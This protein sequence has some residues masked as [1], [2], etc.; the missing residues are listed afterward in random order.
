MN[1]QTWK[2][3]LQ[4]TCNTTN[5]EGTI[6]HKK[7]LMTGTRYQNLFKNRLDNYWLDHQYDIPN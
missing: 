4:G 5:Q 2:S 7:V 6:C 3:N 1:T